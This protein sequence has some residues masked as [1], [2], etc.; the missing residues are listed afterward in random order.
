[1]EPTLWTLLI[2]LLFFTA[3]FPCTRGS[4]SLDPDGKDPKGN[5]HCGDLMVTGKG[6]HDELPELPAGECLEAAVVLVPGGDHMEHFWSSSLNLRRLLHVTV[7][8]L[9]NTKGTVLLPKTFTFVVPGGGYTCRPAQIV[10]PTRFISPN[11]RSITQAYAIE[12]SIRFNPPSLQNRNALVLGVVLSPWDGGS[13]IGT[14]LWLHASMEIFAKAL[15][16]LEGQLPAPWQDEEWISNAVMR[17][18]TYG[19]AVRLFVPPQDRTPSSAR[20]RLPAGDRCK[21]SGV[22]PKET[23]EADEP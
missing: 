8:R 16:C 9:G 19:D 15:C 20:Q 12:L 2:C 17:R 18:G 10:R 5:I 13:G 23:E 4:D 6:E 3:I 14:F 22:H 1:M 7:G 21:L 11:L